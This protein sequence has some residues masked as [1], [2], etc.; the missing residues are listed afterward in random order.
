[1]RVKEL[2]R[3]KV[4]TEWVFNQTRLG[5]HFPAPTYPQAFTSLNVFLLSLTV[6]HWIW[7]LRNL[8]IMIDLA[9]DSCL[10]TRWAS[11]SRRKRL[12]E[13]N[14]ISISKGSC[15]RVWK[16]KLSPL[17]ILGKASTSLRY[18][19]ISVLTNNFLMLCKIENDSSK[20]NESKWAY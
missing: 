15:I 10:K 11:G 7:L 1:M 19:F 12:C 2:K 3:A 4:C 5:K 18:S 14:F 8:E 17:R 20:W 13:R 16:V 6:G 9:L